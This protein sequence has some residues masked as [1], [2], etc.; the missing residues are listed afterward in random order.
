M[1]FPYNQEN[2]PL[3]PQAILAGAADVSAGSGVFRV[4]SITAGGTLSLA[5]DAASNRVSAF[6]T[7][8]ANL[9]V[10]AKSNDAG[11][12][13]MSAIGGTAGDNVIVDG[14]T[15]T[16]SANVLRVSGVVSAGFNGLVAYVQNRND[17]A[18]LR[19]SAF[20]DSGSVSAKQSDAAN[21]NVSGKSNDGA[22]FRVSAIQDSGANLMVSAKSQDGGLFRVSAIV[23]NG[24]VSAKSGDANQLHTSAVQ[25]DAG[26]LRTS[27]IQGDATNL[28]VS[29]KSDSGALFRVSALQTA[30]GS[31]NV[32]AKSDDGGTL[33]S[34]ALQGDAANL[35]VSGILE[36][37][38]A[39]KLSMFATSAGIAQLS[40]I[41]ASKA[42]LY[43]YQLL[44]R[45]GSDQWLLCFNASATSAVTLGT[46]V[47][48]KYIGVPA[49]GGANLAYALPP[50][51]A[52]GLVV[53]VVSA[54]GGTTAGA[55]AM[56][57]SLDYK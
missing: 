39:T 31:L 30:A 14:T 6:Q 50:T 10:S 25:G 34:S 1:A 40:A 29:A 20:V 48:D 45:A 2:Q 33:R 49:N 43:G 42:N 44:N 12:L 19:V 9:M 27:A 38:T 46:T 22:L 53:A 36:P 26:L 51:F 3:T 18:E 16:I 5:G 55:S 15:M 47:A 24:S 23:D 52:N 8:A 37:D 13:R 35:R 21:L 41:K 7:D 54:P 32:S 57:V 17:A 28:N 4:S 11:L 56:T